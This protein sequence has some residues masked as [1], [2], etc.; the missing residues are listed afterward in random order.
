MSNQHVSLAPHSEERRCT[1]PCFSR[2][3]NIV[4]DGI[5]EQIM[6]VCV[7]FF[8]KLEKFLVKCLNSFSEVSDTTLCA[9]QNVCLLNSSKKVERPLRTI[10]DPVDPRP[11]KRIKPF[12]GV[13]KII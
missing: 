10:Y 5:E 9:G 12:F 13:R 8:I 7:E 4:M 3:A 2:V 6:C 11:L 1:K